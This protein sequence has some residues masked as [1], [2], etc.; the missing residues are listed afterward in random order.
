V[1][2][3]FFKQKTAY[4]IQQG[5]WSSDCAL[6]IFRVLR[7]GGMFAVEV[8]IDQAGDVKALFQ[9]AGAEALAVHNDLAVRPRVVAGL[10]KDLGN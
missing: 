5:D 7:P 4:E 3:F 2:F 9:A 6:P 8:G 1:C 10:K